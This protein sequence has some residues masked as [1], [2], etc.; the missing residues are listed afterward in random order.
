MGTPVLVLIHARPE[1]TAAVMEA[2]RGWEISCLY[3]A[4][5]GPRPGRQREQTLCEQAR[6]VALARAG[7]RPV[8]TLF[9]DH[10]LGLSTAISSAIDWFFDHE[11]QGIIL[12]DDCIP[13]ASFLPFCAE[14]LER[15]RDEPNVM[16]I[17]G[18]NFLATEMT[19]ANSYRF[20][21]HVH[22]WGWAT[23]KRAWALNDLQMSRWPELRR[24]PWL[25]N[26][27]N[28][29]ARAVQYWRWIFDRSF[30]V[31]HMSWAYPWTLSIWQ[32]R[33][34][35]I[36]PGR[37]LVANIGFGDVATNT[38][39]RPGWYD[40]VMRRPIEF[41]LVHPDTI[42]ADPDIEHW[43]DENIFRTSNRWYRS[44]R[45]VA[46]VTGP[47]GLEFPLRRLYRRLMKAVRRRPPS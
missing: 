8:K 38:F 40:D 13:D 32:Q 9:R 46:R 41:P 44:M 10:N 19:T 17:S 23:W 27:C 4:A 18:N 15:Y 11:E 5:D 14:L 35:A 7:D 47:I 37:N 29:D 33:G 1:Q 24:G 45:V 39:D 20:T 43:I 36:I 42:A 21:R 6:S 16:M 34:V 30:R 31:K 12:E 2:I 25:S 28:N 22:I 3:I 26:V